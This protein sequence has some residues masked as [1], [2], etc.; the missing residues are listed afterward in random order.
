[1]S[2]IAILGAGAIGGALAQRL[3][4]WDRTREIRLIDTEGRIAEGKA[5]DILQS[6]PI[7]GFTTRVSGTTSI[8]S[9]AGA[10]AI[11]IADAAK[12]DAEHAGEPGLALLKRILALEE[13]APIVFAGAA[14]RELMARTVSELH[15]AP[16]RAIGSAPGALEAAVRALVALELDSTGAEVHLRVV[17]VPPAA[18]LV[19]WESATGF[20]QPIGSVLP[21]HVLAGIS[22]RL[23][24]L[25]PPGPLALASAASRVAEAAAHGSRR[26]YSSFV[27]LD[28]APNRGAV[29]A[30]PAHVGP[31][32]VERVVKPAL[33]R[34][35]QTLLENALAI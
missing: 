34:Q 16:R 24:Q 28:S 22:A 13:D 33:S 25:W 12:T 2:F 31:R 29:V 26:R 18:A 10:A 32:G 19:A 30:L 1:M 15:L 9:A 3:A 17:G 27:A 6:G 23:P 20:G 5:L 35:E 7:D 21:P 11:V 14:Q 4:S 8:E